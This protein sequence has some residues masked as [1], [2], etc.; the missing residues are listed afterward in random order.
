MIEIVFNES[1]GGS[2]KCSMHFGKGPY[3]EGAGA[4]AIIGV[5]S[6][7]GRATQ[8]ELESAKREWMERERK[9][10]ETAVPL[11]GNAGDV[12][13]FG[14]AFSVGAITEEIPGPQ[15]EEVLEFLYMSGI[16]ESERE[17]AR[18]AAAEQVSRAGKG[19]RAV[20][21]RMEAGEPVRVWYSRKPDE[22]CGFCWFSDWLVKNSLDDREISV[23]EQPEWETREDGT[24]VAR[25]GWGET[26][27]GEF[28]RYLPLQRR[29]ERGWIRALSA[30]WERLKAEN[31]TLRAE[32]NGRL[33]TVPEDLYDSFLLRELRE[34]EE[35][36]EGTLIGAVFGK[37]QLGIGDGWLH[38][39]IEK[40]IEDGTVL[41]VREA[42]E[43][44]HI[45]GRVLRRLL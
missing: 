25:N 36:R 13:C 24:S 7:G 32:L 19:L 41:V 17:S 3:R 2:L 18:E 29:A 31:G 12:F 40:M 15:R 43:K 20:R 44:D 21:E 16:P 38:R 4:F 42:E 9:K 1:A 35:I 5:H 39:R 34:G 14:L 23:I 33:A 11:G 10:W 6:D 30:E 28:W 45:Y 22:L 37:Y 27:P 8:E 26:E